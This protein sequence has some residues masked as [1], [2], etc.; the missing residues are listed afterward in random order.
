MHVTY[1]V[2]A[3]QLQLFQKSMTKGNGLDIGRRVRHAK[4]L[5]AK[6]VKLYRQDQKSIIAFLA[7]ACL[8]RPRC[9]FS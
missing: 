9:G 3:V 7:R 1:R 4:E 8:A 2:S 5:Y 6:L